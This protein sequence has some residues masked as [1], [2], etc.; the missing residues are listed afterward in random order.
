MMQTA[1]IGIG[2]NLG[3]KEKNIREA[4]L[5]LSKIDGMVLRR[6]SSIYYT[7]P[8]GGVPQAWYFNVVQ[9]VE[10]VL[11][12]KDLLNALLKIEAEMGRIRSGMCDAPRIIDLDILIFG[13]CVIRTDSLTLPHPHLSMRRFVLEPLAE[14]SEELI[15]PGMGATVAELLQNLTDS[16]KVLRKGPFHEH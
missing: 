7:E 12:P 9:E 14:I 16:H 4:A 11:G 10:T 2:S 1:Y 6:A 13:D 8:V 3:D 5:R 15:C